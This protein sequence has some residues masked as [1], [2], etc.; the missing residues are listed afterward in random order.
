MFIQVGILSI[1]MYHVYTYGGNCLFLI[2][3]KQAGVV[4]Q[5][6]GYNWSVPANIDARTVARKNI[7][8]R[9]VDR[10]SGRRGYEIDG[11]VVLK[12]ACSWNHYLVELV[13]DT[14]LLS[15]NTIELVTWRADKEKWCRKLWQTDQ[16]TMTWLDGS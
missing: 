14:A 13:V 12:E 2:F 10:T 16:L 1:C 3:H 15:L 5:M 7:D 8:A 4:C 11:K 6:V 9:T